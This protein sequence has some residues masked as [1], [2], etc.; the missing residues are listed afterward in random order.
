M[1]GPNG[2]TPL[3]RL[4]SSA[5]TTMG[6]Y[7]PTLRYPFVDVAGVALVLQANLSPETFV[8]TNRSQVAGGLVD[9][10][11]P[12][13]QGIVASANYLTAAICDADG[14]LP[15]SVCASDGVRAADL[16]LGLTS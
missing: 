1:L 6:R 13:T 4:S 14:E 2:Y 7:D 15:V 12:V 16:A 9:P 10:T 11:N 3:M 8:G 5:R